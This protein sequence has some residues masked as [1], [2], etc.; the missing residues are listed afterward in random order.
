M[1]NTL[2]LT[3]MMGSGKT[4]IGKEASTILGLKFYDTDLEIE[5]TLNMKI[6]DIFKLKGQNYFRQVEEKI[7]IDLI[8]GERK[9][10][11]LGGGAFLNSAIREI[12]LKK[13]FSIW[14]NVN[15][16][17]IVKRIKLSKNIRP[18]L[19][20]DNLENSIKTIL[21][22]RTPI[23]KMASITIEANNVSKKKIISEI[24]KNYG[25]SKKN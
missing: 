15:L 13:S 8:N 10:V 17:T 25:Q 11:A 23:Y 1:N 24:Q 21:D 12:V 16:K 14:I 7:C 9:I 20:Y 5:K 6:K 19:D 4:S 22:E 2:V 3:G 18:M